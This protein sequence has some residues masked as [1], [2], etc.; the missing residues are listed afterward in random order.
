MQVIEFHIKEVST[1]I[2]RYQNMWGIPQMCSGKI[3]FGCLSCLEYY[4]GRYC[5]VHTH[6]Y[7]SYMIITCGPVLGGGHRSLC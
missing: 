1:V 4:K 6:I 5:T 2:Q 3:E 7:I